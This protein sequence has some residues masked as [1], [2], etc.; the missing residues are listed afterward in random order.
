VGSED[1]SKFW[2]LNPKRKE[3]KKIKRKKGRPKGGEA[4]GDGA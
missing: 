2:T 1:G 3:K 4:P